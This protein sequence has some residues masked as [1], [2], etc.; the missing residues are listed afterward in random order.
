M[1]KK[2][3]CFTTYRHIFK[4]KNEEKSA[5]YWNITNPNSQIETTFSSSTKYA[6]NEKSENLGSNFQSLM[7]SNHRVIFFIVHS[8]VFVL[9]LRSR[10]R[11]T[12]EACA[13]L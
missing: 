4:F 13:I 8:I 10:F 3:N 1:P 12:L 11:L 2:F 9:L 5:E 7:C 6:M